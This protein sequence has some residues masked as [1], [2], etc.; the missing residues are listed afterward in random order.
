M[1]RGCVSRFTK[2]EIMAENK[3]A[4]VRCTEKQEDGSHLSCI[5]LAR[6]EAAE[7]HEKFISWHLG[8][9]DGEITDWYP[10]PSEWQN[11]VA[12]GDVR[13]AF[14]AVVGLDDLSEE[15][16]VSDML[17]TI[18]EA[19]YQLAMKKMAPSESLTE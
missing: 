4:F 1:I 8:G 7:N 6:G 13:E 10:V 18:F 5:V 16:R 15:P 14:D 2:E 17:A 12:S 19:G 3:Y 9:V 11:A